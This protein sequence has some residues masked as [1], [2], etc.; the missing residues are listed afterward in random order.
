M[1]SLIEVTTVKHTQ[2]R[3][4]K[5]ISRRA[6]SLI[7]HLSKNNCRLRV[8]K[9]MLINTL[10]IGEWTVLNWIK[11]KTTR[12]QENKNKNVN[13]KNKKSIEGRS[14]L[15]QFFEL[16]PKMDSHYCRSTTSR[17]Y[18]EPLWQSK[19]ELFREYTKYCREHEKVQLGYK[20]FLDVFNDMNLS[21]FRP[22]KD[23]CDVCCS[24][25]T[26][27]INEEIYNSHQLKK[28]EARREKENDKQNKASKV[29]TMDLQ[30]V[31]L[32]PYLKASA[33]YYKTKLIVHNFTIFDIIR[34]RD[35]LCW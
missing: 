17:L 10:V 32:C 27:N 9:K 16:L 31:L 21:L 26:K 30:S 12:G 28:E 35:T 7:F 18:L 13:S 24:Y 2:H 15:K 20:A 3:Q 29:Y 11:S 1:K 4:K 33:L 22:K 8:C 14:E 34:C 25:K 5:E 23:Q 19:Q 6:R